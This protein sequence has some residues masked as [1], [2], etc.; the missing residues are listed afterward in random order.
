MQQKLGM[1][2]PELLESA[3]DWVSF[4]CCPPLLEWE[5]RNCGHNAWEEERRLLEEDLGL[6]AP[7]GGHRES[8]AGPGRDRRR[9]APP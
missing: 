9:C 8:E 2:T 5:C 1:P 7:D 3:P 4:G 6:P